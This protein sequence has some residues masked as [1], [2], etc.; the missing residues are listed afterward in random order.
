MEILSCVYVKTLSQKKGDNPR[1][2]LMISVNNQTRTLNLWEPWF[3]LGDSLTPYSKL[4]LYNVDKKTTEDGFYYSAGRKTIVVINPD[5]L[6]NATSINSVS[7]CP[8]SYYLNEIVGDTV[9]PYIATRG[10]IIH[11]C[12]SASIVT[13]TKPSDNLSDTIE[14]FSLKFEYLGYSKEDVHQDLREMAKSL[15]PFVSNLIGESLTE[16]LFLSP[17]LGVRGRIDLLHENQIFELKTAKVSEDDELRFSDLLQVTVYQYGLSNDINLSKQENGTVIYVGTNEAVQKTADPNWGLLRYAMQQRNLAYLISHQGL[18][19]KLLPESQHKK[20]RRCSVRHFCFLVCAGLEQERRCSTCPH[21]ELCTQKSLP[22]SYKD[23]FNRFTRWIRLE[24]NETAENLSNLWKL[25]VDQRVTKG[26]TISDLNLES[27]FTELGI[28]RLLFSCKNQSEIREGDIVILSKGDI[29]KDNIGTGIVSRISNS[30]IEIETRSPID[31]ASV[32]DLYSID[33]GFRRQQ[34]G[35]FNILFKRN[36]FRALIVEGEAPN[37]VQEKGEFI[38]SNSVQNQAVEKILGTDNYCLI[39]GPAGTGKTHVIAKTAIFLAERS[40]KVLLTAFTNRAVDNICNYLIQ[41]NFHNFIRLGATHSIQKEIEDYTLNS[42]KEKNKDKPTSEILEQIPII[43]ATTSTISNPVFEKLGIQT[44]IIDEASQMTEPTVVSALMEGNRF[45]LVGDHKQL[46]PVVQSLQAQKEGMSESMFE[47]FAQTFPDSVHL[48]TDQFRM[49]DRIIEY[50]NDR[51]Y[52]GKLKAFDNKVSKQNL[53]DLKNFIG[54][55]LE[56]DDSI[57][58]D[59]DFPLVFVPIKGIF[60]PDKKLNKAEAEKVAQIASRFLKLGL[61]TNQIGVI[62]P[63]RGQVGEIRRNLTHKATVDTVDR[64][65]GS[66]REVIILSL[67]ETQSKG[68]KGFADQRRLNVALTRAKKKL[69]VVGDPNILEEGIQD[70][71]KYLKQN[72][73]IFDESKLIRKEVE[74]KPIK[75]ELVVVADHLS[76]TAKIIKK[77]VAKGKEFTAIKDRKYLCLICSD[78]VYENAIECPLCKHLFHMDH[79]LSWLEEKRRCPNCRTMLS[80]FS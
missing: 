41:N 3:E 74:K 70:Y 68:K 51:F 9:S 26:K 17:L 57:I 20:C 53:N 42:F 76:K 58:Y 35:L 50:S 78:P 29:L 38:V 34:R 63:Y 64:F 10:S 24:R 25:S 48:L 18:I 79:L 37:I 19:P 16:I 13:S 7:Y 54:N 69:V 30:S 44:I 72:A 39:Q 75:H 62:C 4:L 80:V 15:D 65:Q 67:T 77:V 61:S 47:R 33:V 11:N 71:I 40:E 5:I 36:N 21:N 32:V 14:D 22:D 12:L 23:Y 66:D 59:P 28:T 56:L 27:D 52:E 1:S 2:S 43:V 8:R 49:N 60:Q 73:R 46:P 55:F 6:L 31:S 45:V